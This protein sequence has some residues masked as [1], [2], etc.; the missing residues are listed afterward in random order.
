VNDR[1]NAY[2]GTEQIRAMEGIVRQARIANPLT[3]IVFMY[4]ADPD[5]I[6]DYNHGINPSEIVNHEKVAEHYNIP[7]VNLA[8]E[9]TQRINNRE[10]TWE[11]DFIDLHPSPF[12]QNLYYASISDLLKKCWSNSVS[13]NPRMYDLP[14][15][16]DPFSYEKGRLVE[17]KKGNATD[18]WSYIP[19]WTP[20]DKVS[21]RDGYVNV[22]M[23]AGS[24]PGKILKFKFK[25]QTVGIAVAAGPDAGIIEYSI[26]G[27]AWQKTDLFTQWSNWLH[28]PWFITLGDGLKNGS[29]ELRIRLSSA[30]NGTSKGTVCRIRYFFVN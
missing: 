23:L 20:E 18:G 28:L 5:K 13:L 30:W 29:H 17:V 10:F 6:K 27:G 2:P 24:V 4:F 16:L 25:G 14:V 22:P 1:T 15:R 8:S 7:A 9:V 12:G 26:D 19:E 11:G 21:T 3:D